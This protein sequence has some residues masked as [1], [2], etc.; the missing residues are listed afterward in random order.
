QMGV[1]LTA[2]ARRDE[3]D[4]V[5]GRAEEIERVIQILSRRTKNNPAL[6]GDP[7]VGKTAIVEGLAQRIVSG[8]VPESLKGRRLLTL[9]IGS[10]VAG[11]KYRGEFEDRVK[12]LIKEVTEADNV[13]LFV[14]EVHMILGAGDAVGSLDAANLLKPALARGQL[15]MIGA[16]TW[17]EYRRH[18]ANDKALY[19][20]FQPIQ[21]EEPSPEDAIEIM[22]GLR[23]RY[24]EFH[25][26]PIADDALAAAVKLSKRYLSQRF[27]PDKAIDLMDEALARAK[28][29][30]LMPPERVRDLRRELEDLRAVRESLPD[31]AAA[32]DVLDIATQEAELREDLLS[33]RRDWYAELERTRRA[34]TTEDVE[35]VLAQWTGVP[36]GN[37]SAE[38][39]DRYLGMEQALEKRVVGQDEAVREVSRSLRRAAAGLKDA[40]R[41]IGVFLFVGPSGVGKSELAAALTEFTIG[42]D[43]KLIRVDMGE[44]TDRHNV[45]RLIGSPPGYVGHDEG[46]HVAERVRRDP[47]GVVL[48]DSID[49]A[50]SAVRTILLQIMEEGFLTDGASRKVDFRN[51]IVILTMGAGVAASGQIGFELESDHGGYSQATETRI[52]SQVKRDLPA[53]FINRI[54]RQ[55]LFRKL[56]EADYR[57]IGRRTLSAFA[58]QAAEQGVTVSFAGDVLEYFVRRTVE[59]DDGARPLR[60]M[61]ESEVEDP[62]AT[63]II[64]GDGDEAAAY[65]VTLQDGD[66]KIVEMD[67]VATVDD[68]AP[69]APG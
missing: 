26:L 59:R 24:E 15:R 33:E 1:D 54:D 2:A 41:P 18:V 29:S 8:D 25:G 23:E 53:E 48:F 22:H 21:V 66:I 68:P 67:G 52:M 62:L 11:T 61:L 43:D 69:A 39:A 50:H 44:M 3:L 55:I 49:K 56:E 10:L 17:E 63:R 37:V 20:R 13:I 51:T 34:I 9:D 6:V 42:S 35:E 38:A 46:G 4:P 30:R 14:D 12:R 65:E 27:L 7:G 47:Y 64:E 5:I 19:R 57:E 16:T 58:G 45:S 32:A 36:L 31:D 60:H 28:V 40:N